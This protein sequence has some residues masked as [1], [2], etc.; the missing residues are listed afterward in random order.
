M[1]NV[2][3][4]FFYMYFLKRALTFTLQFY[5]FTKRGFM[6]GF[7]YKILLP[8]LS[9]NLNFPITHTHT[10]T[11][12]TFNSS[13]TTSNHHFSK[14]IYM[15]LSKREKRTLLNENSSTFYKLTIVLVIDY[16]YIHFLSMKRTMED[17]VQIYFKTKRY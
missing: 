12:V 5:N 9:V 7:F 14:L 3:T 2:L 17:T 15:K 4:V 13:H 10:N 1:Y 16:F 8:S 11:I 6:P